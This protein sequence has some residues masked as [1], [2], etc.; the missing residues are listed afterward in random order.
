MTLPLNVPVDAMIEPTVIFGVPVR[1]CAFTAKV[2]FDA[3]PVTSPVKLPIKV[4]AVVVPDTF[5]FCKKV[6]F[7]FVRILSVAAIPVSCDPL[8][9]KFAAV[10]SPLVLM[11]DLLQMRCHQL[12]NH[13][14]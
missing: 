2:E 8:P 11:L 10:I 9:M 14:Q 4:V 7:V 13:Q 5:T 12:L 1:P 3:V 6:A